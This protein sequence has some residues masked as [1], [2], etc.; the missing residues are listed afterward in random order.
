MDTHGEGILD[1]RSLV[2]DSLD[3]LNLLMNQKS[4]KF[5]VEQCQSLCTYILDRLSPY[6]E[7]N[8]QYLGG[9]F[10]SEHV[11]KAWKEI[12]R[13][14][15]EAETYLNHCSTDSS[16][17]KCFILANKEMSELYLEQFG[18]KFHDYWHLLMACNQTAA[19]AWPFE[20]RNKIGV[21]LFMER[22]L[23]ELIRIEC[24]I[25]SANGIPTWLQI[26]AKDLIKKKIIGE[27]AFGQVY[28]GSWLGHKVA[29]KDIPIDARDLFGTETA[30]LCKLQSPFIVQLIGTCVEGNHCYIV[31]ELVSSS[32]DKLLT[33]SGG[34]APL[35]L[36]VAVDMMLQISRGMEYLHS[37]GIMHMDLKASN[38]LIQPSAVPEFRKQSYGRVKLCDFGMA[39]LR[40]SSFRCE[41]PKGTCYWRA[42]E[43]FP[44][45]IEELVQE[46]DTL[47][48]YTHK[49]DVYSFAMT[50]YEILTGKQPFLGVHPKN[51]YRMIVRGER[52]ILQRTQC[53]AVLAD[54]IV[55]CWETDPKS[56][57]CF[58]Q[59]STFMRNMKLFILRSNDTSDWLAKSDGYLYPPEPEV[60]SELVM[61][62]KEEFD[63][64]PEDEKL[65][66]ITRVLHIIPPEIKRRY[67][68]IEVAGAMLSENSDVGKDQPTLVFPNIRGPFNL[69]DIFQSGM[70]VLGKGSFGTT[71]KANLHSLV[72]KR[73]SQYTTYVGDKG[74]FEQCLQAIGRLKHTNLVSL[75]ACY[76]S[77]ETKFLIYKYHPKGS[78]YS[79]LHSETVPK[80]EGDVLKI[81]VD[82]ALGLAFVHKSGMVHGNV[83]SSNVLLDDNGGACLADSCLAG[84][85]KNSSVAKKSWGY[86][87]PEQYNSGKGSEKTDVY[88]FGVLLIELVTLKNPS[89]LHLPTWILSIK[90]ANLTTKEFHVRPTRISGEMLKVAMR[91]TS[92]HVDTRPMMRKVVEML[93]NLEKCYWW[94]PNDKRMDYLCTRISFC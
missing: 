42:P 17:I 50:C 82:V 71:Y 67:N 63:E 8:E 60:F 1:I 69:D 68:I 89:S 34:R 36:P 24:K 38:V 32:L 74:Y 7:K 70:E 15:K 59:I 27:G 62:K 87:A 55:K 76:T 83:K 90:E 39:S 10:W 30:V 13:A 81:A 58:A 22:K 16:R 53:P 4:F 86:M 20:H 46:I 6:I 26:P 88:S 51:L 9:D 35:A 93:V 45:P 37:H 33:N 25:E 57:P 41:D 11:Q 23:L 92:P 29:I 3:K 49:A 31:M 56:R 94:C 40:L 14:M 28:E 78:L 91:C 65:R 21:S 44:L 73:S 12:Y 77:K 75:E 66:S 2:S 43:A 47:K 85:V 79:L 48:E 64:S 61:A 52:P 54:F 80:F 5:H 19:K 18:L 84:L 72:V